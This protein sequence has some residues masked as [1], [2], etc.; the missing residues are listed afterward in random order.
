MQYPYCFHC[1]GFPQIRQRGL[2][3][4]KERFYISSLPEHFNF[5]PPDFDFITVSPDNYEVEEVRLDSAKWD[6]ELTD[7]RKKYGDIPIFATL[8]WG[9][10][11]SPLSQFTQRLNREEQMEFLKIADDFFHRNGVIFIY[12]IRGGMMG[13]DSIKLSYG[14]DPKYDSTAPEFQLYDTIKQLALSKK[15]R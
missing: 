7:I 6:R 11:D 12:P 13:D 5:P 3:P 14:R 10:Y 15:Q 4:K 8:D 1:D 2:L 9:P